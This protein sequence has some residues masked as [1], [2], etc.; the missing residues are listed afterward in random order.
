ME[1]L[2]P[3]QNSHWKR[4]WLLV[5]RKGFFSLVNCLI[6]SKLALAKRCRHIGGVRLGG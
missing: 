6:M 1:A 5:T 2:L 3:L 4:K